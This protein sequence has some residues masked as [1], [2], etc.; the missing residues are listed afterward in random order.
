MAE[1]IRAGYSIDPVGDGDARVVDSLASDRADHSLSARQGKELAK[2]V[3]V[4]LQ[5]ASQTA[6]ALEQDYSKT[7]NYQQTTPSTSWVINHNLGYKPS[8]EV[9]N[10]GSQAIDA[11]IVHTSLNQTVVSFTVAIAGFARLN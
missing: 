3:Q 9:F 8:V 1:Y 2:Q 6:A 10:T 4:S 5:V 11:D 7:L